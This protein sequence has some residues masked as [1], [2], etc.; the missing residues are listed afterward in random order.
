MVQYIPGS[1]Q[2]LLTRLELRINI[3]VQN[4]KLADVK[5]TTT[6][7]VYQ[8]VYLLQSIENTGIVVMFVNFAV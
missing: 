6:T 2:T 5:Q 4:W 7:A 1:R 3:V 8:M